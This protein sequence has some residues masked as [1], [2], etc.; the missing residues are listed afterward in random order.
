MSKFNPVRKWAREFSNKYDEQDRQQAEIEAAKKKA[1]SKRAALSLSTEPNIMQAFNAAYTPQD[2]L[3][4]Y[5]YANQGSSFRHPSSESG[6]YSATVK[7]DNNGIWRVNTLSTSDPLYTGQCAHDA[8]SVFTVLFHNGDKDAAMKDAGDNLLTIGGGSYNKAVQIEWAKKNKDHASD[9][10][11]KG[12]ISTGTGTYTRT[13]L[14]HHNKTATSH[15]TKGLEPVVSACNE[16]QQ[17]QQN[18]TFNA[19]LDV[20]TNYCRDVD[21][22]KYLDDESLIKK[23]SIQVAACCQ[24]P[25]NTV[26]LALLGVFS[27]VS[28]RKWVVDY[29]YD[30]DLPIGLYFILEQPSGTSKSRCLKI[31]QKPFNNIKEE[32]VADYREQLNKLQSINEPNEAQAEELK[33]LLAR[34]ALINSRVFISNATAEGLEQTLSSTKGFFSAVS[35]EQGLFDSLLGLSYSKGGNN[36][37]L[38]LNGFDGGHLSSCRVSREGFHG[39]VVGAV[40]LFAQQGSIEKAYQ[41]SNGVGISERFISLA[42]PHNLGARDHINEIKANQEIYDDYG[43]ACD[44]ARSVFSDPSEADELF[45]LKISDSGHLLI[46]HYRQKI[47][48][49]LVDGGLYSHISLRGAASKI[50]MQI[51]KIAANLY[52][53]DRADNCKPEIPDSIIKASIG[54]ASDLLKANLAI[55]QAKGM[56]G[57]R[58]EFNAILSIF[59][60]KNTI[61]SERQIIQS[62]LRVIPF[63]DFTGNKSNLVRGALLSMV[64]ADL[65][66]LIVG[67]GA[68]KYQLKQ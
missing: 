40:V 19:I 42:E 11:R 20:E 65:L 16:I 44:F 34:K 28:C 54:I 64:D 58:A 51:M 13:N 63:K 57:Q 7:A 46:A 37:D 10:S 8:F 26:F 55:C 22:L 66:S 1:L 36:N 21:L 12:D 14:Q 5:G 41:S 32:V 68:K 56:T 33:G 53:I 47:E 39:A 67:D 4:S 3:T 31:G 52:L 62:R 50:N 27:S 24:L 60:E 18:T 35:S 45:H 61:K 49:H 17:L 15:D 25:V 2:W 43:M 23:M 38:I 6:N 30:G 48:K 59:E 29:K 9:E